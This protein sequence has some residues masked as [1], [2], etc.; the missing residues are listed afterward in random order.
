MFLT[1]LITL[2]ILLLSWK[3][4]QQHLKFKNI[5]RPYPQIPFVGGTFGHSSVL[6]RKAQPELYDL[7]QRYGPIMLVGPIGLPELVIADPVEIKRI[8]NDSRL[9]PRSDFLE[10]L[11]VGVLNYGLAYLPSGSLHKVYPNLICRNT[12]RY[13]NLHSPLYI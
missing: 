9:F 1:L 8:H 5:P 6:I 2:T 4:I 10:Y 13:C 7:H 12:E 3:L 11:L